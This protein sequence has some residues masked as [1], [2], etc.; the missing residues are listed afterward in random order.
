MEP[1]TLNEILAGGL[2][3]LLFR[4]NIKLLSIII[5]FFVSVVSVFFQ[6][7]VFKIFKK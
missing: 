1:D 3:A 4:K 7:A 2:V 6:D 5:V